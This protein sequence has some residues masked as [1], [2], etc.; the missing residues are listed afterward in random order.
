[1]WGTTFFKRFPVTEIVNEQ[2]HLRKF[3]NIQSTAN[4]NL[5]SEKI[6]ASQSHLWHL[7]N[8]T[9]SGYHSRALTRRT[10]FIALQS[11]V[12]MYRFN[13]F[14]GC[15]YVK[16]VLIMECQFIKAPRRCPY[17]TVQ[18]NRVSVSSDLN[19]VQPHWTL[20]RLLR[21][22]TAV[23]TTGIAWIHISM[24]ITR[25]KLY[26]SMPA[27]NFKHVQQQNR[28]IDYG[29]CLYIDYDVCL[30]VIH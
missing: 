1:M 2:K 21:V 4:V 25:Y 29:V 26:P 20:N 15:G 7:R 23:H 11:L 28:Q 18:Q 19:Q 16:I 13:F 22:N 10:C 30:Y 9:I 14:F 3:T 5:M 17:A 12:S 6:K 24:E 27:V 8:G